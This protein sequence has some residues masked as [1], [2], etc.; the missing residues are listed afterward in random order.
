MTYG[1]LA[2]RLWARVDK[3]GECWTWQGHRTAA[4]YGQIGRGLAADGLAYTHR[5]A[6]ELS[7]GPIP[8]EMLVCHRC[9]NPPCVR[10]THLFVGTPGDN[11]RDA[12]AKGRLRALKGE[13]HP[14]C[15]LTWGQVREIRTLRANGVP[16]V[17]IAHRF[18]VSIQHVGDIVRFRK[19]RDA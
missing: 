17:D 19:R 18:G 6:Y 16:A 10:P 12:S 11:V 2:E 4:G 3:S 9:D 15:R 1:S 8:S 5:V 14:S 13:A 7:H